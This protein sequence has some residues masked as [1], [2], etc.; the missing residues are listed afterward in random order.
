MAY[1]NF[2]NMLMLD[3]IG[4]YPPN[5]TYAHPQASTDVD[6]LMNNDKTCFIAKNLLISWFDDNELSSVTQ[7]R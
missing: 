6:A 5:S 7:K 4:L 2:S 1:W 3:W